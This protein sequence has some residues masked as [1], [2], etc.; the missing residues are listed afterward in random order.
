MLIKMQQ[1]ALSFQLAEGQRLQV[2]NRF[3]Q[4]VVPDANTQAIS[5]GKSETRQYW[6]SLLVSLIRHRPASLKAIL[7]LWSA[8]L[9]QFSKYLSLRSGKETQKVLQ[10]AVN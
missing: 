8:D 1:L 2:V 3:W 6:T 10:I 9:L 7:T 5:K 4:Q